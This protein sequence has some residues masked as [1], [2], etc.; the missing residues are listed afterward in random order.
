MM[1]II[2]RKYDTETASRYALTKQLV[3]TTACAYFYPFSVVLMSVAFLTSAP[4]L[5]EACLAWP[6]PFENA[7]LRHR[8]CRSTGPAGN[9]FQRH[10]G[11]CPF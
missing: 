3:T 5:D 8:T 9:L 2:Q 6:K 10:P 7:H 4:P 1:V 11:V